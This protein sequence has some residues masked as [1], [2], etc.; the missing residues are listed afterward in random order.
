[1]SACRTSALLV[2][3]SLVMAAPAVATT[4]TTTATATS[5]AAS[6]LPSFVAQMPACVAGCLPTVGKEIGCDTTDLKCMCDQENV[7]D[8]HM[9]T[10][11]FKAC[12]KDDR[13]GNNPG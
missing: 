6:A 11:M 3:M 9:D 4:T 8:V 10:C 13:S 12:S 5:V 7:F 2:A 1:M